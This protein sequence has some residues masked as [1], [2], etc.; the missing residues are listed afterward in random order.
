MFQL[1]QLAAISGLIGLGL[2]SLPISSV[3]AQTPNASNTAVVLPPGVENLV[4]LTKAGLSEDI[5][6]TQVRGIAPAQ[7]TADQ[8]LYLNSAGVSQ[9]VIR[10]LL[11]NAPSPVQAP[12]AVQNSIYP[13]SASTPESARSPS[14]HLGSQTQPSR[15]TAF[16]FYARLNDQYVEINRTYISTVFGLTLADRGIAVDGFQRTAMAPSVDAT[17]EFI[18]YQHAIDPNSIH[19]AQLLEVQSMQA[20]EFN[21]LGTNLQFF[22]NVYGVSPYAQIDVNLLRP[23]APLPLRVEPVQDV[24]DMYRLVPTG[25]LRPGHNYAFYTD[26]EL[27]GGNTVFS[28]TSGAPQTSAILFQAVRHKDPNGPPPP[29]APTVQELT[30]LLGRPVVTPTQPDVTFADD[31]SHTHVAYPSDYELERS[32]LPIVAFFRVPK[33]SVP[34]DGFRDSIAITYQKFGALQ[35]GTTLDDLVK[36]TIESCRRDLDDVQVGGP[37]PATLG[38]APAQ[39]FV[40]LGSQNGV[41]LERVFLIAVLKRRVIGV[42]LHATPSTLMQ[43]WGDFRRVSDSYRPD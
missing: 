18:V 23:E 37:I 5:I 19:F 4:K 12:G 28:S 39:L 10:A 30:E 35:F 24:P 16:G 29:T 42:V 34:P 36:G 2:I 11:Q 43:R 6:L 21:A 31:Q 38:G 3:S 7:L 20:S 8:I 17:A 41:D 33:T 26:G 13:G 32:R 22:Q 25:P 1:K 14:A 9:N 15:P 40:V 27:H